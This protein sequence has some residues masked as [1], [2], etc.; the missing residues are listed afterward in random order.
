MNTEKTDLEN[1][2]RAFSKGAVSGSL[3][4]KRDEYVETLKK[5]QKENNIIDDQFQQGYLA[6]FIDGADAI[7]KHVTGND[8]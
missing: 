8:C 6:G 7:I 1:E 2:N 3:P 4:I 5:L